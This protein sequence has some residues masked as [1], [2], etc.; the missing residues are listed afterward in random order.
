MFGAQQCGYC[1]EWT[2]VSFVFETVSVR[3]LQQ[4]KGVKMIT[5]IVETKIK[6]MHMKN[7]QNRTITAPLL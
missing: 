1:R 4:K 2:F 3:L 6:G 7:E 5:T